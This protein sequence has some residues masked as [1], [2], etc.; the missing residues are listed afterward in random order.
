MC[1]GSQILLDEPFHHLKMK[2]GLAQTISRSKRA[3]KQ[4]EEAGQADQT[5]WSPRYSSAILRR[6]QD[7]PVTYAPRW[8]RPAS[9][10]GLRRAIRCRVSHTPSNSSRAIEGSRIVLFVFFGE[11]Q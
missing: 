7:T 11:L 8:S 6:T 5:S 4:D 2:V 10:A 9:T 3:K 1:Y